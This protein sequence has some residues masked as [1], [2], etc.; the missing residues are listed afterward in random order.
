MKSNEIER[1]A[2]RVISQV[3]SQE[4]C[5]DKAVELKTEWPVDHAKAARRI[6]GH[7]NAARGEPIL[8]LIGVDEKTGVVGAE[9][10]EFSEWISVINKQFDGLAPTCHELNVPTNSGPVVAALVFETNR[11]PYVAK[12]PQ[13][14]NGKDPVEREVPWREGTRIRSATR[15]DLLLITSERRS[16]RAL[17]GEMEWNEAVAVR[18]GT[19]QEQF[20]EQEFQNAMADGSL[21]ELGKELKDLVMDAYLDISNAQSHKRTLESISDGYNRQLFASRIGRTKAI[22][23]TSIDRALDQLRVIVG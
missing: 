6:A 21:S 9:Y 17:L 7:C 16:L 11:P 19:D 2:L 5:E 4:P 20:R 10:L 13:F 12:N 1:W 14:G 8:W 3:E 18:D 23:L 15:A 22:A